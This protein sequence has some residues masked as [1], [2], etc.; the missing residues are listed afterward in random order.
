MG[1]KGA[2]LSPWPAN[3]DAY[4]P[5][6]LLASHPWDDEH[7]SVHNSPTTVQRPSPGPL[8]TVNRWP[9]RSI[10]AIGAKQ[11]TLVT[12]AQLVAIGASRG[13]IRHARLRGRIFPLHR[14]V[15]S[16]VAPE[17]LPPLAREQAA[18]LACGARTFLSHQSAAAVWAIRPPVAGDVEVTVV[19]REAG[20]RRA[21]IVVHRIA[22]P[23]PVRPPRPPGDPH[24]LGCPH[25]RRC[26]RCVHGPGARA[27]V[28]RGHQQGADD[29]P[30]GGRA[31]RLLPAP[32]WRARLRELARTRPPTY[33]AR[34]TGEE[35]MLSLM[36]KAR[37]PAPEVNAAVGSLH[38]RLPLACPAGDRRGRRLS[39]PPQPRR[40]R[41]R[42]PPRHRASGDGLRGPALQCAPARRGA[43]G[44][45][46]Q[47]PRS[48][49]RRG[50]LLA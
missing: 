24:H 17:A 25:L 34:S 20:R 18:V 5:N 40:L 9:E 28:R 29:G 23:H 16:L 30:R 38:R 7:A 27:R 39:L 4:R 42:S 13:A 26:R 31:C 10:Q 6:R 35:P 22:D 44:R 46:A 32:P 47:S 21:G 8:S 11:R 41:P 43:G 12:H 49:G 14:G 15:Y 19:G 3:R 48:C 36:R 37:L 2:D 50:R 1:R 33:L 45:P